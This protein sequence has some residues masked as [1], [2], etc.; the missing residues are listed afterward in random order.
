MCLLVHPTS[1]KL[2][3]LGVAPGRKIKLS[4][5]SDSSSVSSGRY[6]FTIIVSLVV[7]PKGTVFNSI[8]RTKS[9]PLVYLKCCIKADISGCKAPQHGSHQHWYKHKRK[10]RHKR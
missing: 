6:L 3:L 7:N 2:A 1:E 4:E 10:Q 8:L 5:R 9:R